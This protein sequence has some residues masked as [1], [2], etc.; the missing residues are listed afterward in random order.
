M[1][2]ERDGAYAEYAAVPDFNLHALPDN[3]SYNQAA[4][5]QLHQPSLPA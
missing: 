2:F 1:G 5:V 4:A 3:V